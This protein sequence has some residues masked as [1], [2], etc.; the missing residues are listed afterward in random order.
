MG[1]PI[2][3]SIVPLITDTDCDPVLDTY[4]LLVAESYATPIGSLPTGMVLT[5]LYV[6]IADTLPDEFVNVG[7]NIS[8]FVLAT[9]T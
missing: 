8:E 3:V 9:Y 7:D 2:N 6:S 5:T 4:I 1:V